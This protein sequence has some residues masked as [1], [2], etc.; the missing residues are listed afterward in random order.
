MSSNKA[1]PD[2]TV[3][4]IKI[5]NNQIVKNNKMNSTNE[6]KRPLSITSSTPQSPPA[7]TIK[8]S[9]LFVMPNCFSILTTEQ[10]TIDNDNGNDN[11][12]I[13]D[14]TETSNQKQSNTT[15]HTQKTI[16]PLPIFI[17][18][19]LDFIGLRNDIKDIIGP[20]S[21]SCKSNSTHLKI[22]TDTPDNYRK[23]IHYLKNI[24]IQYHTYQLQ[25]DKSLRIVVRNLHPTTPETDI[26]YAIE[27]I[28]H[29]VINVTNVKHNQTKNPLPLFFIDIDPKK[30]DSDIFAILSFLHI[31]VKIE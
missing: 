11:D 8:K 6:N 9:K 10:S 13:T 19:V 16:L 28:S 2:R 7:I 23:L 14:P 27:E 12:N 29:T 4:T 21:F 1:A 5:K 15:N 31:K 3:P 24:N 20:D 18:G 30:S 22:Q 26:A 17:K 25:S